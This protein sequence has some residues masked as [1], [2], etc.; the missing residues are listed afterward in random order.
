MRRCRPNGIRTS[1]LLG[2]FLI[3]LSSPAAAFTYDWTI[4]FTVLGLAVVPITLDHL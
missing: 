3:A 2:I 4:V 1:A